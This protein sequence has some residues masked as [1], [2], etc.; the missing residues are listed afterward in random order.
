MARRATRAN[1]LKPWDLSFNTY[2][3][4]DRAGAEFA[5]P[6][7]GAERYPAKLDDDIDL[8]FFDEH[9]DFPGSN[10]R[11]YAT[12]RIRAVARPY[13]E[14]GELPEEDVPTPSGNAGG[15]RMLRVRDGAER[16]MIT[17]INNPAQ[18]AFAQS[19]ISVMYDSMGGSPTM[20]RPERVNHVPLGAHVLFM[21]GHVDF[22]QYPAEEFPVDII[23]AIV[24]RPG[25]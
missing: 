17:D 19:Q 18:Q 13:V 1:N 8:T 4:E 15:E 20:K 16:F 12:Q 22:R 21:D 6:D 14:A 24:G 3:S 25:R 2:A 10:W 9:P 5:N 7:Y 23:H 11:T